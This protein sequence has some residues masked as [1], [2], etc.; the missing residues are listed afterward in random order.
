MVFSVIL[1]VGLIGNLGFR[2][3]IPYQAIIGTYGPLVPQFYAM[4]LSQI[5][6]ETAGNLLQE[7]DLLFSQLFP[8]VTTLPLPSFALSSSS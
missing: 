2:R 6:C 3:L 5:Y 7:F 4:Q 8:T 1:Q